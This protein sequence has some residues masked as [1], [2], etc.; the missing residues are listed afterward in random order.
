[1]A[2][3][4]GGDAIDGTWKGFYFC[5]MDGRPSSLWRDWESPSALTYSTREVFV[6]RGGST[7]WLFTRNGDGPD[8]EFSDE[9]RALVGRWRHVESKEPFETELE[10]LDGG[11]ARTPGGEIWHWI[12]AGRCIELRRPYK[13]DKSWLVLNCTVSEDCRS[14]SRP[15]D[16]KGTRLDR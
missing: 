10:L 3:T 7:W 14:Y 2:R 1:M 4:P 15:D 11:T 5:G 8:P 9:E 6:E 12:A 13:D 16:V